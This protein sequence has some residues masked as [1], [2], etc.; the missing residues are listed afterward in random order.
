MEWAGVNDSNALMK[1]RK[2]VLNKGCN[3]FANEMD[4]KIFL[5]CLNHKQGHIELAN[6][7]VDETQKLLDEGRASPQLKK[8]IKQGL[9]YVQKN[10]KNYPEITTIYSNRLK[11]K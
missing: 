10:T 5:A 1:R 8:R 9:T 6:Q 4:F 3:F 7:Y 11:R 2:K